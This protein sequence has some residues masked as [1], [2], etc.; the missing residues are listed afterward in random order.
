MSGSIYASLS[1]RV[2]LN[3]VVEKNGLDYY[4][5]QPC[6][7]RDW[8]HHA[9]LTFYKT[10]QPDA[11]P[12]FDICSAECDTYPEV[13]LSALAHALSYFDRVLG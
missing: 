11:P 13:E 8:K 1:F 12:M 7:T 4:G 2:I 5:G 10:D 3:Q 9:T 6:V